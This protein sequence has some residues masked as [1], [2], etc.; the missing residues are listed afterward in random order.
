MAINFPTSPSTNDTFT[1]GSIT[2]TWDGAKWIG[3]GVT[4]TDKLIEGSNK[5]EI[6][7]SNNLV[8]T[9]GG[10]LQV[11]GDTNPNAVFDRGSANTTNVNF[12]YNGTLTG[13]LGAANA[14][15]QISAA[16][17]S[18]PLVAYVNGQEALR[19]DVS[20]N[21]ILGYAGNSLYFQNGFNNRASRIQNG[22]GSGS[23]DLKFFTNDAGTEAERLR[24]TSDGQLQATGAAD[25]RLT[26]GSGGTAGT[27]NSVHMRAD[28]ANLL[29][30][31][32]SGGLTKFE[33][34]GTETL[35]ISSGGN[36]TSAGT[37]TTGSTFSIANVSGS[38]AGAGGGQDYIGLRHG[39]TFGLILK[40]FGT[41]VGNVGINNTD[42]ARQLSVYDASNS[43]VEIKSNT[44]GQSSVFF[45]DTA[46]GNI[47]MIGYMHNDDS[48]F[49]RVNDQTRVNITSDGYVTKPNTPYF[50]VQGS[51]S[52]SNFTNYTNSVYNFATINSNNGSHYN[53]STG[54]FTAPVAG[55]YWFSCGLWSSNGDDSNGTYLLNLLRDNI[56]GG[57]ATELQF[58]GANHRINKNQLTVSAGIYMTAGQTVRMW[59]NG[60]I[61][62]STPRNYFSG[63]LVG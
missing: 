48:M 51:P 17:A 47:G 16:G 7:G 4:P 9:G 12:N 42:P 44:D 60:S 41:N 63:Y 29:F 27:N 53:N 38:I 39:T 55:F 46:D 3:L 37:I 49:F 50:S 24:I 52:L 15:F 23:A 30:M 45:T 40:T 20:G 5:L 54:R 8:W 14:E 61:Q 56:G 19:V 6:D 31:N 22:G 32:A 28:G 25:V 26:L 1:A 59:Y 34:N 2:Y 18:T 35:S 57:T 58:A 33:S 11:K 10:S 13:Q 36:I 21:V 43:G 62:G